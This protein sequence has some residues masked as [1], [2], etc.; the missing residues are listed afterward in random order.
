MSLEVNFDADFEFLVIL[1]LFQFFD[2]IMTND[3]IMT[4]YLK[5]GTDLDFLTYKN[6]FLV[7]K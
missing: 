5:K 2:Q 6:R 1:A 3:R 7:K 4:F